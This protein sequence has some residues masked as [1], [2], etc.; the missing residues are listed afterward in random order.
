[1][2]LRTNK[3][4]RYLALFA[5]DFFLILVLFL[6]SCWASLGHDIFSPGF[7]PLI[8]VGLVWGFVLVLTFALCGFYRIAISRIGLFES[9]KIMFVGSLVDIVFYVLLFIM[10]NIEALRVPWVLNWRVFLLMVIVHIFA[11]VAIRFAPRVLRAVK[12]RLSNKSRSVKAL[13]IGA[14]DAAKILIDESRTN[15]HSGRYFAGALDDDPKKWGTTIGGVRVYGDIASAGKWIEK[16]GIEE[17]IL[18]IPSLTQQRYDE[19]VEMLSST[20]ARIR[21]IPML[22]E[23]DKLNEIKVVDISYRDLLG[24][25][26]FEI[27]EDRVASKY[28][29]KTILITGGGGSIGGAIALSLLRLGAKKIVLLDHYENGVSDVASRARDLIRNESLGGSVSICLH[30]IRDEDLVRH[31][32]EKYRPDYVFHCAAVKHVPLAE[33]HPLEAIRTNVMGTELLCKAALD[34]GV[35]EFFFLST[36]KAIRPDSAMAKTK[37]LGE[38]CCAYYEGKGQTKFRAIRFGNVL[39][40]KG[41]VVT[42]FTKQIEL[43]GP[44]TVTSEEAS[45]YFFT[46]EDCVHLILESSTLEGEWGIYDLETGHSTSILSLAESLIRQAGYIPYKDIDVVVTGLRHG[47]A[48]PKDVPY[49]RSKQIETG[50]HRI[51]AE[52]ESHGDL[53]P[54]IATSLSKAKDDD[55]AR[56]KLAS[57]QDL[58]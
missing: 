13:L 31:D 32:F 3:I 27:H 30:S 45:R 14:G 51:Y 41:S 39:A 52:I 42:V 18:A 55:S 54:E 40:S 2:A 47:E 1:M 10:Q 26:S 37:R 16:L 28:A 4:V 36:D 49:D 5:M 38:L 17:V 34:Y 57:I 56:E 15:P 19:I 11:C 21:K 23:L 29:G 9:L 44:V 7:V 50:N 24:R 53:Y 22:N 46:L 35:K 43:G 33:D 58:A 20:N 25:P 6:F 8:Y 12:A 48:S